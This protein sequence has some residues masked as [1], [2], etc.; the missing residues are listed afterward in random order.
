MTIQQLE[1]FLC[2]ARNLNFTKTAETFFISQSAITQQ[3]KNLERELGVVL[4]ARE[5]RKLR[6][7]IP[8]ELFVPEAESIIYQIN[9][10]KRKVREAQNGFTGILRIGYLQC[11]EMTRFPRTI[12]HF[13]TLY[14]GIRIH[15]KRDTPM[16]LRD[17][18]VNGQLDIIFN[19]ESDFIVYPSVHRLHISDYN[20]SVVLPPDHPL[21][22]RKRLEQTDLKYEKLIIHDF[23][24]T[25]SDTLQMIPRKYLSDDL[26][27]NIVQMMDDAE[28]ILIMVAAK[29]GV[30][31]L[32]DL[33]LLQPQINLDLAYVPL[34]TNGYQERITVFY[35][36]ESARASLIQLLLDEIKEGIR[37]FEWKN[38][39]LEN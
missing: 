16:G 8:G 5:N 11:M 2:A 6:L 19:I 34:D 12:Q 20:Y 35:P 1:Y 13:N 22:R 23:H 38:G 27:P 4:F 18:L 30:A 37:K 32:P 29:I 7:T 21:A 10:A 17:G 36:Q 39:K 26:L 28:S 33:D 31:V 3:I 24:R 15:L 25:V 9:E 14:P